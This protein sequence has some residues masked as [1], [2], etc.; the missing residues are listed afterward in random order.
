MP[1]L[2]LDLVSVLVDAGGQNEED[3]K[4]AC[5]IFCNQMSGLSLQPIS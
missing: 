2:K 5:S 1:K 4:V 3:I